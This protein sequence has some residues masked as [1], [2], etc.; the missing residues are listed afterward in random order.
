MTKITVNITPFEYLIFII[1]TDLIVYHCVDFFITVNPTFLYFCITVLLENHIYSNMYTT[2][3]Q[4]SF[5]NPNSINQLLVPSLFDMVTKSVNTEE[6][7]ND[8]ALY[9]SDLVRKIFKTAY[10]ALYVM[11]GLIRNVPICLLANLK[12]I[13][14]Q[15]ILSYHITAITVCLGQGAQ[16]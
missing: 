9:V 11:N 2:L 4:L 13:A 7:Y 16:V 8:D 15:L 3:L 14:C 5:L 10:A 1:N 12:S 6:S